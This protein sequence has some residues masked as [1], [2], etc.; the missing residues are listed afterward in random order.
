MSYE[1]LKA[2]IKEEVATGLPLPETNYTIFTRKDLLKYLDMTSIASLP[3][4]PDLEFS[5][6]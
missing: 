6:T 1:D 3:Q 4:K 2:N 5:D